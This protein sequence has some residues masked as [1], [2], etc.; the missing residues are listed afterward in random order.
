MTHHAFDSNL[1]FTP[2]VIIQQLIAAKLQ[3]KKLKQEVKI[4]RQ[5]EEKAKADIKRMLI[6]KA[7]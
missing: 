6:E 2:P 4:C 1:K 3:E 7:G 5:N